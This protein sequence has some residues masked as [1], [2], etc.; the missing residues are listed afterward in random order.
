MRKHFSGK[1]ALALAGAFL[2]AVFSPAAHAQTQTNVTATVV[3]PIGIPY[4]NGTYSVQLI[5]SGTNPTVNGN[6][7]GG[8]FNGST[9]A[10]GRFNIA[11]WPNG[12]IS[13]AGTKWQFTVC[14]SPGV[15]PPLGTGGQCTPPTTVTISGASQS[16]SATLD[17]VAPKLTTITLGS[18]SVTSVSGSAPIVATPNP[19]VGG[20]TIS[21]PTCV[22]SATTPGGVSTNLQYN[23][24]GAFGGIPN[25]QV[26]VTGLFDGAL[27]QTVFGQTAPTGATAQI[28]ILNA[29]QP[30]AEASISLAGFGAGNA[31]ISMAIGVGDAT[32]LSASQINYFPNGIT[33]LDSTM[34]AFEVDLTDSSSSTFQYDF[35]P[36]A[37]FPR[38]TNTKS[39]G[40]SGNVWTN[41]FSAKYST[42]T[43]CTSSASPAVCGSAADGTVVIAAAATTVVVNTT[44]VT[45][46]SEIF[47]QYDSSLGTKLGVTCNTTVALP[48]VTARTPATSFTITVPAAPAV[49]PACYSYRIDN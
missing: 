34:P 9:D 17:A 10:N 44:A 31:S 36:T 20:G 22:T 40:K 19:I 30:N 15:Q 46:N 43:N 42:A 39:L 27:L 38:V 29:A 28:G 21:C 33:G 35:D 14:V 23:N 6:S 4:A 26:G 16:L 2:F 12:N 47:I 24:A 7:I 41:V 8:A 49:N 37:F 45:A 11:L 18:G 1:T 25:T 3:D 48:A 13:P 32:N 5:P